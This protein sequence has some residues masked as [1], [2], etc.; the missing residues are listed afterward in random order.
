MDESGN[1]KKENGEIVLV[2]PDL[3]ELP[4]DYFDDDESSSDENSSENFSNSHLL[5]ALN[6]SL[7]YQRSFGKQ[8]NPMQQATIAA[9]PSTQHRHPQQ[10]RQ[11]SSFSLS[12]YRDFERPTELSQ[13]TRT[14]YKCTVCTKVLKSASHLLGHIR[15]VCQC[16]YFSLHW[17]RGFV[18]I[19]AQPLYSFSKSTAPQHTNL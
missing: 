1:M 6:S 15:W 9:G 8:A 18:L 17:K 10:I 7:V 2:E 11:R 4:P 3:P 13:R 14:D 5:K 16:L 12:S 19:A